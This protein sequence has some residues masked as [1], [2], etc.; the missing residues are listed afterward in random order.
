[1]YFV[2]SIVS[3]E[4]K[5]RVE[6][7]QSLNSNCYAPMILTWR[8]PN[9]HYKIVFPSIELTRTTPRVRNVWTRYLASVYISKY[10]PYH[11]LLIVDRIVWNSFK[12]NW[13]TKI[14][15]IFNRRNTLTTLKGLRNYL[16]IFLF[17]RRRPHWKLLLRT[18]LIKLIVLYHELGQSNVH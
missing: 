12:R 11:E 1:M 13:V 4:I 16:F 7:C 5:Q 6:L 3:Y 8:L 18:S 10:L 14:E 15:F 17:G 2:V 9:R